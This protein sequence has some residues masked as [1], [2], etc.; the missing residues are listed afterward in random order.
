MSYRAGIFVRKEAARRAL[1]DKM[2]D[3]FFAEI[4]LPRLKDP[5]RIAADPAEQHARVLDL[6][7]IAREKHDDDLSGLDLLEASVRHLAVGLPLLPIGKPNQLSL[8]EVSAEGMQKSNFDM[9]WADW[10][11][12]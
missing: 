2:R 10:F 6:I 11:D 7:R 4:G 8:D 1:R 3:A 5:M 12:D 9:S